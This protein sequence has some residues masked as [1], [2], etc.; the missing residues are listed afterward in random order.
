MNKKFRKFLATFIATFFI[1]GII[2]S[3]L[4][5]IYLLTTSVIL[6]KE[7][8]IWFLKTNIIIALVIFVT[9]VLLWS[10][11]LYNKQEDDINKVISNE[12]EIYK[13]EDSQK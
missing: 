10:I 9:I 2:V 5:P 3:L 8:P 11:Y 7:L 1:L 12:K 4:T 13:K 6:S